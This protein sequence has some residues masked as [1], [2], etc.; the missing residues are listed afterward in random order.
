MW[1]QHWSG[2]LL[3]TRVTVSVSLSTLSIPVARLANDQDL[4]VVCSM[5][6]EVKARKI[7]RELGGGHANVKYNIFHWRWKLLQFLTGCAY[8][9]NSPEKA[10]QRTTALYCFVIGPSAKTTHDTSHAFFTV[11]L[12]FIISHRPI[13]FPFS[14]FPVVLGNKVVIIDHGYGTHSQVRYICEIYYCNSISF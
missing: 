2:R 12:S 14:F 3:T 1:Q 13:P 9:Q 7:G 5:K 8:L 11:P 4:K 6:R 10:E